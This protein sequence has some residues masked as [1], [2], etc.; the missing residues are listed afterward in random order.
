MPCA[1]DREWFEGYA[2][3][4]APP[5]R[6]SGFSLVE[7]A[8]VLAI[9]SLLIG[10]GLTALTP[11]RDAQQK[12]KAQLALEKIH[13]ALIGHVIRHGRLPCP[14]AP[15]AAPENVG[16]RE[17]GLGLEESPGHCRHRH[18][19]LPW[20]A[21][22]VPPRDPWGQ[23]FRYHLSPAWHAPITCQTPGDLTVRLDHDAGPIL[24]DD[25][26]V[27]VV[28]AGKE[29]WPPH[30]P[31]TQPVTL[32]MRKGGIGQMVYPSPL[33]LKARLLEAGHPILCR[34]PRAP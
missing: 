27:V 18:G 13:D 6:Q 9:V 28:A 30:Q 23:P 32:V 3:H 34:E 7:L 2:G 26:P 15:A 25:L 10:G 31:A 12:Q 19:L 22:G 16:V 1:P 5:S 24:A 17:E 29:G 33:L 21:L 11:L 4:S 8:V 14:D 20:R